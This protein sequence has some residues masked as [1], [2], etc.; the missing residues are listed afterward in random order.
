MG[1]FETFL[2]QTQSTDGSYYLL[3]GGSGGDA[4]SLLRI[5]PAGSLDTNFGDGGRKAL[6]ANSATHNILAMQDGGVLALEGCVQGNPECRLSHF[7]ASGTTVA[8][9]DI[10]EIPMDVASQARLLRGAHMARLGDGRIVLSAEWT[11]T[12]SAPPFLVNGHLFGMFN[13]DLSPV[14]EFDGDNGLIVHLLEFEFNTTM[15]SRGTLGETADGAILLISEGIAASDSFMPR[16]SAVRLQGSSDAGT[17]G[18]GVTGPVPPP[19]DPIPGAVKVNTLGGHARNAGFA[20]G[21]YSDNGAPTFANSFV[22]GDFVTII[23]EVNPDPVDVGTDGEL[24]VAMLS[25]V[26]GKATFTF[27]NSD[28]NFE[29]WDTTLQGLG[30][31]ASVNPL[32]DSHQITVFEGN[33]QAGVHKITFAYMAEGGPLVFMKP[34]TV[35]VA[36]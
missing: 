21:A 20:L 24:F 18:S 17:P 31:A 2:A 34:I 16:W 9:A 27:L 23:G 35:S 22:T 7:S 3:T 32:E 8:T 6:L 19:D 29:P 15:P 5:T 1:Q 14:T 11:G 13:E 25:V 26:G 36:N 30:S 10:E 4:N 12:L 28:G 33:L